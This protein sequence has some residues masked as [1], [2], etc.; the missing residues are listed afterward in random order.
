MLTAIRYT[1]Y[2]KIHQYTKIVVQTWCKYYIAKLMPKEGVEGTCWWR[3][4]RK[5]L[6][7]SEER[8][9]C[10][11]FPLEMTWYSDFINKWARRLLECS[12][13]ER[14]GTTQEHLPQLLPCLRNEARYKKLS[15]LGKAGVKILEP[16]LFL[17][18]VPTLPCNVIWVVF[19]PRPQYGDK[20]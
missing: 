16:K 5:R 4:Y 13:I 20:N 2:I 10:A 12:D 1:K 9:Q 19:S 6:G 17:T 8:E 11:L 7:N 18:S 3:E 15:A 14:D